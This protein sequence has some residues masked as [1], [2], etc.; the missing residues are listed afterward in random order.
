[1]FKH[2]PTQAQIDRF[3]K[4]VDKNGENGCWVWTGTLDVNKYGVYSINHILYKAHRASYF[5]KHGF[6]DEKL[7]C[8]HTCDN[9]S[10][11]NPDHLWMGTQAEN[12]KDRDRKG[13]T[14]TGH[15]YGDDNP[16]AK[17]TSDEVLAIREMRANGAKIPELS[18]MFGVC[19]SKIYQIIKRQCWKHI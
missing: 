11:V 18:K 5:F 8:C 15:L 1:M 13:R 4:Y 16:G 12:T 17:L 7:S 3:W 10:C 14:R 9:P 19:K 2:T 6:I